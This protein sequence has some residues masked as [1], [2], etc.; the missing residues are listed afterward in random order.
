MFRQ[1]P[2]FRNSVSIGLSDLVIE[3]LYFHQA[4]TGTCCLRRC[5]G[6]AWAACCTP[7]SSTATTASRRRS[8]DTCGA[9]WP[10]ARPCPPSGVS[11]SQV[12][13]YFLLTSPRPQAVKAHP[14]LLFR[15]PRGRQTLCSPTAPTQISRYRYLRVSLVP[16]ATPQRDNNIENSAVTQQPCSTSIKCISCPGYINSSYSKTGYW[17]SILSV[18]LATS[19]L[20]LDN[21]E[22]H[23]YI[24]LGDNLHIRKA[25]ITIKSLL[26]LAFMIVCLL[27][28]PVYTEYPA[29]KDLYKSYAFV[30]H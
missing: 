18:I 23:I 27:C 11:W 1:Y 25:K 14:F 12:R 16:A 3:I 24:I 26:Q 9:W 10:P 8:S 17:F 2:K 7:A 30:G 6:C 13:V 28:R 19:I 21:I 15:R 20:S 4:T 29:S 5:T 22:V